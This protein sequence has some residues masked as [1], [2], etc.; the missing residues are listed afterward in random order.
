MLR[1]YR[2]ETLRNLLFQSRVVTDPIKNPLI[3]WWQ[4]YY[5]FYVKLRDLAGRATFEQMMLDQGYDVSGLFSASNVATHHK[6]SRLNYTQMCLERVT[7]CYFRD[8]GE[9]WN[10]SGATLDSLP[11]AKINREGWWNSL[12]D[13]TT[14]QDE[15]IIDEGGS[16][17]LTGLQLEQAQRRAM[18]DQMMSMSGMD[19]EDYLRLAGV[20][21]TTEE[22][23]MPEL[24]RYVKEWTYPTNTV[25]PDDGSVAS[26]CS[27]VIQERADKD[28][29][30]KEPGFIFGATVTRPKVYY[31]E[32]VG[33]AAHMLDDAFSWL[34]AILRDDH[35]TSLKTEDNATAAWEGLT[36]DFVWDSRDL[37]LYGDQFIGGV[38]DPD[39]TTGI[40]TVALPEADTDHRYVTDA[41]VDSMF[42]TADTAC[43]VRQDGICRLTIATPEGI[44]WTPRT[45]ESGN[46]SGVTV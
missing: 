35:R 6:G 43:F 27:W 28:R 34:P 41:D 5:F 8:D 9:A 33:S 3:G 23:H 20:R 37:F 36:N 1:Y 45:V 18:F 42:V 7:E 32:A 46:V 30:F 14:I 24:I 29:F 31:K 21:T 17:T 26:A 10:A 19:F 16:D 13:A 15:T 44:D 4:E 12:T 2:G 40:N 22:L 11:L 25:D 38:L 39:A